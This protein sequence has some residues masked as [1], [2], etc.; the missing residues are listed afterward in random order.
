VIELTLIISTFLYGLIS[1]LVPHS[2]LLMLIYWI[3]CLNEHT[4]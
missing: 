1:F 3:Y 4:K 2:A